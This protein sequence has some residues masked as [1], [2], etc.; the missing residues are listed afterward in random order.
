[1]QVEKRREKYC[2]V[3]SNFIS[4]SI[5]FLYSHDI[6]RLISNLPIPRIPHFCMIQFGAVFTSLEPRMHLTYRWTVYALILLSI[7]WV[8]V[9]IYCLSEVCRLPDALVMFSRILGWVFCQKRWE[10]ILLY[11]CV[12]SLKRILYFN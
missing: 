5:G 8:S 9:F 7:F 6:I 3:I 12:L 1:M 11:C 4:F 2:G 10:N